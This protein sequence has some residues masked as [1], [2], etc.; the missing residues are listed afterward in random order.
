MAKKSI[1][2]FAVAAAVIGAVAGVGEASA[3]P[4]SEQRDGGPCYVHEYGMDSADGA[5]YCSPEGEGFWRSHA[6]SRA[7]KVRLGAPCPKLGA[8]AMVYQTDGIATCRQSN[9]A[10]LRWQW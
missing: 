8:R 2:G 6:V 9:S 10:G 3:A 1:A 5:L 7:P 4:S